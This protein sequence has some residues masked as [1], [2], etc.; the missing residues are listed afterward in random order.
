MDINQLAPNFELP[1][2]HGSLH[3]LSDYHGKI[4]IINFWSAECIHSERTDRWIV[5]QLA[6]WNGEVELLPIAANANESAQSADQAA[7]A[8]GL[9]KV[10]IDAGHI[11]ADQYEV[12]TTP[13]IFLLDR[14]GIL[15]YRGAVDDVAFRQKAATRIYLHEAVEALMTG[16]LPEVPETPAYGCALVREI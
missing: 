6:A 11:V 7:R 13:H 15:R 12:I 10:L 5:S 2:L 16:R 3:K 9:T 14:E 8:R 4:V 1:D